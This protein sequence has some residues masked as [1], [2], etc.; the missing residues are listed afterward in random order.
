[1]DRQTK[2][3]YIRSIA[4]LAL[5]VLLGVGLTARLFDLQVLNHD[6]YLGKVLENLTQVTVVKAE[7]GQIY[8]RN[9]QPLAINTTTYR[10][11]I[12][13]ADIKDEDRER[14]SEDLSKILDV[15]YEEI[16]ERAG[17]TKRKDE[18]IKKDVTK[19]KAD[20]VR[21]YIAANGFKSQI[22]LEA[23]TK[24]YYPNK[25]LASQVIG[26]L[27]TDGGLFG[28][29]LQYNEDL[30]GTDGKYISAKNA[31]SQS[32]PS[33]YDERID[34]ENG[35]SLVTTLDMNVQAILQNQLEQT[36]KENDARNDVCGIVMDVRTGAILA[37]ATNWGFDLNTPFM[38]IDEYQEE[39]LFSGLEPDSD[40][41]NEKKWELLYR[42]WRN[43][44]VSDTYEPGSTFKIVTAA[45]GLQTGKVTPASVLTCTGKYNVSGVSISCH[46]HSGHGT[47]TFT[48][49]LQQS[50]NPCMMQVAERIGTKTFWEYFENFGYT[51]KTGVDL[52]GESSGINHTYS[53]FHSV[54]LATSSFGQTFRTTPIQQLTAICTVANGG[55]VVKPHVVSALIDSDGNVVQ[56]FEEN[57]VKRQILSEEVCKELAEILEGGVIDGVARNAYVAGYHVAAKTG[58]SE[59]RDAED[60]TLRVGSTVAFAPANDP[61]IAVLI[62][63]DE[64]GGPTKSG[65][66]VA[67]P[68]V[69]DVISET[70]QYLDVGR[71][72]TEDE[73]K[74]L[75]FEVE[76]YTAKTAT[77]AAAIIEKAG[78][79]CRIVGEGEKIYA[80]IPAEGE[81]INVRKGVVYLYACDPEAEPPDVSPST[82][83]VP[84]VTG[85][86][87][88][89]A[90]TML[91]SV[92]LNVRISGAENYEAG[93]GAIVR[94][95]SIESG[96]TVAIGTVIEIESTHTD[97]NDNN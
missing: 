8:D 65:G 78:V 26:Y 22:Y 92:G 68:Y 33:K 35:L 80:Q 58:T 21:A 76:D 64:P 31:K 34:P 82:V 86:K 9:M 18:T 60:D 56:S 36:F 67:A 69:A 79:T 77:A 83:T 3:I 61:Q 42:M 49:L 66:V 25:N 41:Y 81:R 53:N 28:L 2:S 84:D 39:L 46:K 72:Y 54:E 6:L 71:D 44:C 4:V 59:K 89:A 7:R 12:S 29:E 1:M 51:S 52:P 27:G 63:V 10:V 38:L 5:F 20:E 16:L 55:S 93:T 14:I 24:R 43:K 17:R 47:N 50:C 15:P 95:Q 75:S 97:V 13:P 19:D 30:T 62:V 57:P 40:E 37:M 87:V 70:L 74:K 23:T 45:I 94:S 90:L 73:L 88:S 96:E 32:M 85:Y 48:Y 91:T 11:F